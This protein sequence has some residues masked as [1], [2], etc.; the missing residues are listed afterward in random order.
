[1]S[2]FGYPVVDEKSLNE[3]ANLPCTRCFS[4]M[5]VASAAQTVMVNMNGQTI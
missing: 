2:V 3:N 4:D 5:I 1:M